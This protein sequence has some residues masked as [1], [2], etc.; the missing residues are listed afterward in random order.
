[1]HTHKIHKKLII[2]LITECVF[3]WGNNYTIA[4]KMLRRGNEIQ[5]K[6]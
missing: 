5:K 3:K 4:E 2:I 1:M 6:I